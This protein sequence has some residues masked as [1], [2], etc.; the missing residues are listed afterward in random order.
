MPNP[1]SKQ[2]ETT[3]GVDIGDKY[4]Q[5]CVLDAD[6][7]VQ[8]EGR[9]RTTPDA[10]RKRFAGGS[11]RIALEAG[12]HSPWVSRELQALGH[13][14]LVANPRKI[15]LITHDDHK[16]DP[17]DAEKLARLARVDPNLL[18]PIC[19]R[20]ATAQADL[21]IIRARDA[22][23]QARTKLI[24][25]V[26]GMVKSFGGALRSC[27][28]AAFVKRATPQL[29][30]ELH[31]ALL[32]MMDAIDTLSRRIREL[33][34]TLA[35]LAKER[36]PEIDVLTQAS[37]VGCLTGMAFILTI[38]DPLRFPKSRDIGPFLGLR[39]KHRQ[40]GE[41]HPKHL[42]IT[43]AGNPLLRRLLINSAHYILG[44]FGQDSDLRRHGERIVA[45]GGVAAKK[46][47]AVA[48]A[49][50]LAVLLHRLWM[51]GEVYE[52]LRNSSQKPAAAA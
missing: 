26:R 4:S 29:P 1:T 5:I 39:P 10:F 12:K 49:R 43:R 11:H 38:E 40:S 37:G 32:P 13:E 28:T 51:T 20:G 33:E 30:D 22:L 41:S 18:R 8:A 52:P 14:V 36:Y 27:S 34:R 35:R 50:K 3:I 21:A 9:I 42:G 15:R 46:R 45:R 25:S 6:G 7:E 24:N 47:A 2:P 48:V 23:V 44:P 31:A 19:H 16:S 17:L